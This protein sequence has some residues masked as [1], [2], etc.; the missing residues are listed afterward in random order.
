MTTGCPAKNIPMHISSPQ[1]IILAWNFIDNSSATRQYWLTKYVLKGRQP[2][3]S[4]FSDY[5]SKK[6]KQ[7]IMIFSL[8]DYYICAVSN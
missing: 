7:E 1:K 2:L 4:I 3:F 6:L 8:L 5:S